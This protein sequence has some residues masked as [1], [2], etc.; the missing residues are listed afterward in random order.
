MALFFTQSGM[1]EVW[2][3]ASTEKVETPI[4]ITNDKIT[5]RNL[6]LVC[7]ISIEI[8]SPS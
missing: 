8:H 1:D 6:N 5:Y 2:A 4:R 7:C 3:I